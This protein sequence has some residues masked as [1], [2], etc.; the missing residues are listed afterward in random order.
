MKYELLIIGRGGQGILLMGRVLGTA[1]SKYTNLYVTSTE[2][3][4]AETR[5]TESRVEMIISDDPGEIDYIATRKPN[6]LLVMY[7][8]NLDKYLD[9]L[10]D[11]A[12]IFLNSDYIDNIVSKPGWKIN[13]GKYN[14]IAEKET[15]TIRTANMVAL[16]HLVSKTNIIEPVFVE[17]TI[18][19]IV[20]SEWIDKNIKAFQAGLRISQ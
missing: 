5:G 13:R 18:S 7:P 20:S 4:G 2:S 12:H 3:Y 1:I 15:G 19:E 11:N 16:G 8:F 10:V 9:K 17:K 14:S 6:I